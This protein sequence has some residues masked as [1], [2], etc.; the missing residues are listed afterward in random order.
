MQPD[1]SGLIHASCVSIDGLGVLL[2]GASGSGKSDLTLRL[3]DRGATLVSDDYCRLK[4][5]PGGQLRAWPP[6]TTAGLLEVRHIGILT[7]PFE[8][9]VP[10]A[11]TIALDDKPE[12][13][14]DR[15]RQ[16][17]LLG[18]AV[19]ALALAP[20]EP[21]APIKVELALRGQTA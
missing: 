2:T 15:S 17:L 12:R 7:M 5:G 10:V 14:P 20:F 18:I 21:S 6:V 8:A 3:V 9:D 13:M 16:I 11:L 4:I 19:P 1:G